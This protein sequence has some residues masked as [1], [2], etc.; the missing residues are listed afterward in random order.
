MGPLIV[1][2]L[3]FGIGLFGA[4]TRKNPIAILMGIELMLSA[5]NL[6]FVIFS[7]NLS[8]LSGQIFALFVIA[9][10]AAEAVVG[11]A[12]IINI[13]REFTDVDVEKINLL[14]W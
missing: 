7:R 4:L 12:I 10:A 11:L 1:S 9:V 6:N 3:L 8:D 14:R 13:Y 2:L 5:A